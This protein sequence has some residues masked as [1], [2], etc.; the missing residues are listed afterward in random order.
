MI[1][2]LSA[3]SSSQTTRF[4]EHKL[5]HD[6]ENRSESRVHWLRTMTQTMAKTLGSVINEE[7]NLLVG[8]FC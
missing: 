2:K 8:Y 4:L 1:L 7:W 3:N 5:P 6:G